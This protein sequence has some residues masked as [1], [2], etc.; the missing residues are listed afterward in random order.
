MALEGPSFSSSISFVL[1]TTTASI[2]INLVLYQ[3]RFL[4][5][6]VIGQ[7]SWYVS[8][9][10]IKTFEYMHPI[11]FISDNYLDLTLAY[12]TMLGEIDRVP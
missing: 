5:H 10:I 11:P 6:E 4:L 3:K 1:S 8:L 12:L 2:T 7:V 9:L